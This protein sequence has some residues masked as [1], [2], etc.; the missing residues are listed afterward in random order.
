MHFS[1][2]GSAVINR[3]DWV[4]K[5]QDKNIYLSDIKSMSEGIDI[6]IGADAAGHLFTGRTENLKNGIV[7]SETHLEW[8]V[9]GKVCN[10]T[11]KH[12]D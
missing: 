9:M 2:Y 6:L 12:N 4:R 11:T 10:E 1:S 7:A 3:A 5:L 8:T